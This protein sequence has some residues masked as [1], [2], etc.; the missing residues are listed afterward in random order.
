MF[1]PQRKVIDNILVEQDQVDALA[2][3]PV[4]PMLADLGWFHRVDPLTT[5]LGFLGEH[6]IDGAPAEGCPE[7]VFEAGATIY[8]D[9]SCVEPADDTLARA[10]FA[11]WQRRADGKEVAFMAAVPCRYPQTAAMAEHMAAPYARGK[12]PPPGEGEILTDCASVVTAHKAPVAAVKGDKGFSHLWHELSDL[13]K[14]S[15]IT[16]TK[17]HRTRE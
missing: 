17:A 7:V 2:W 14:G 10:A 6:L 16:K 1:E 12:I 8:T 13:E 4:L 5:K 11:I 3:Q 15:R 9:G